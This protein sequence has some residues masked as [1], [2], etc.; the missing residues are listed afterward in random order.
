MF[1]AFGVSGAV[2][3]HP[4]R[5][6]HAFWRVCAVPWRRLGAILVH[7]GQILA[8][9]WRVLETAWE[10]FR[11]IFLGFFAILSDTRK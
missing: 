4:G 6:W 5:G 1:S 7:L 11:I 2:L 3:V 8:G 9:F 10:L